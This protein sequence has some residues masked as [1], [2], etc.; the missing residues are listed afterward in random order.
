MSGRWWAESSAAAEPRGRWLGLFRRP[1]RVIPGQAASWPVM[2][3][4]PAA[5]PA[6]SAVCPTP[7]ELARTLPLAR[8]FDPGFPPVDEAVGGSIDL[9]LRLLERRRVPPP[10]A[11]IHSDPESDPS[12]GRPTDGEVPLWKRLMFL[13]QVR[14][15]LL[16]RADG[17]LEWPSPLFE[18]QLEGVR[19]LLERDALLLADDMGLGKTLQTIAALRILAFRR[20]LEGGLVIVPASLVSQWRAALRTWAPELRVSTIRG[21][22]V[23][24]AWQ[25]T[26]PAHVYLVGYETFREDCTANPQSPPRRRDWDVVVL[27]EAQRIKNRE[28]ELSRKCMLLRR[29]RAWALSGTPLENNLDELA[30]ILAWVGPY[31]DGDPPARPLEGRA[32]IERHRSLQLRRRKADVLPQLPPKLAGRI[33]LSLGGKQRESY[34]R[35]ERDGV[36]LLR[37]RGEAA[38]IEHVLELVTRLKQVCNVCPVSG[39]S[40]KLDDLE[41]RMTT[42]EA[43]GHRALVFSQFTDDRFGA[44]AIA[45]RLAAHR[46]L[47]YTGDLSAGRRDEVIR[48]F[49]EDSSRRVLILSLRAGGQGLNLQ[50]ASYVFHFDRWWNPAVERQAEDRSHRLGQTLPVHVYAYTC[51]G[52]IEERIDQVLQ[53]K[54][55]LFDELIDDVS[56]DL[57][58]VLT[59]EELFGL[60]GLAPPGT[61]P[62]VRR[63]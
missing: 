26:T 20:A 40:P 50:E 5:P 1:I 43:E 2:G 16:L 4:G 28:S 44:R 15:H 13:L 60:F 8:T 30:T 37:E 51:E 36:L 32:L 6:Q 22:A 17:P 62:P 29:R 34:E 53:R 12:R 42:L 52:T 25:W 3:L 58:S 39:R 14:P 49:K 57:G 47:L 11:A 24:R 33:I 63:G 21:P 38:R 35:A 61:D 19:A 23:E 55:Q 18:Y 41:Q 56:I 9:F 7:A 31:Q 54:Q 59:A 45:A 27:D 10:W 48:R 46:P